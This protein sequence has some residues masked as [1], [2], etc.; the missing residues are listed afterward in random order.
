MTDRRAYGGRGATGVWLVGA[1]GSLA[2]TTIAGAAALRAGLV[3]P[4]GCVT[5][6]RELASL[7]LPRFDDLVF[8]G[9]DIAGPGLPRRV[10]ELA[11]RGVMPPGL[12]RLVRDE[13]L[14]A[15]EEIRT[16]ATGGDGGRDQRETILT[17]ADDLVAFRRRWGLDRVVVVNVASPDPVPPPHPA[18]ASL[19]ALRKALAA[20]E[21]VLPDSALYACAALRADCPYVDFTPSAAL[22]LPA[23]RE[24]AAERGMPYA[25]R[26][27]RSGE[28]LLTSVPVSV[29]AFARRAPAARSGSGPSAAGG[30]GGS[31]GWRTARDEMSFEGFLGTRMTLRL[32]WR[33]C[34]SVLAAPLVLDLAR[35]MALA[36][37]AGVRGPVRELAFFFEDPVPDDPAD[38][39]RASLAEQYAALVA[40]AHGLRVP[41]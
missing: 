8:G 7:D 18:H 38:A 40:W 20:G 28:T 9:H 32:A 33:G 26:A 19:P 10:E 5:A 35:L 34:E 1:R 4:T 30:S 41:V 15:E 37:R 13:L 36:D 11:E 31:G 21:N 25:G 24:L 16:G 22:R 39:D 23:V 2:A 29:P 17:L 27:G 3:R 14:A 6:R 12:P